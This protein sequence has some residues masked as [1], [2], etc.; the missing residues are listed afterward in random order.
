VAAAQ[1]SATAAFR[2]LRSD[3][4]AEAA[5]E[6]RSALRLLTEAFPQCG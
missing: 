1:K 6:L 4:V 3:D 2:L 5:R